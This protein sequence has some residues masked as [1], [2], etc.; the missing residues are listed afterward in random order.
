MILKKV[1]NLLVITV[2]VMMKTINNFHV[3]VVQKIVVVIL[4]EKSLDGELIKNL[5]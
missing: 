1:R 5:L 3:N 2:L 4:L